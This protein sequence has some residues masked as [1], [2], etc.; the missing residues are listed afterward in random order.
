[1]IWGAISDIRYFIL[2]NKLCLSV[3]LLYPVFIC[4]LYVEGRMPDLDYIIYSG[5]ISLAMFFIL[6]TLFARGIIGGGDVKLIPVV[7]LWAGPDL[8]LI[9]LL[10]TTLGGGLVALLTISFQYLKNTLTDSKSSEN[11]NLSVAHSNEL[12]TN[13]NNIPYGVGI[14]AGGLYVAL[15]LFQ[16]LN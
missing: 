4:A 10:I 9:F 13:E 3:L 1:M 8:T 12:D 14:S 6:V 2:S 11:I 15:K 7:T 16:A 5:A